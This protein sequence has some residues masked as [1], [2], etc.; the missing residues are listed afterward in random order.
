V[1][2]HTSALK[3]VT[4]AVHD[5]TIKTVEEQMQHLD[6]QLHGLDDVVVRI[7]EQNNIHHAA[8][9]ASLSHLAS[10][11]QMSYSSIGDHFTTSFS[12]VSELDEEI[13]TRTS[14]LQETLPLLSADGE[15]R[16]PLHTLREAIENQALEEYK[17]TGETPQRTNYNIS[18]ALPRTEAHETLLSKLRRR[19][20]STP[21]A[22]PAK[23]SL[24]SPSKG[25]I[26]ADDASADVVSLV[27]TSTRPG[28]S[29]SSGE[30]N[31]SLRELDVNAVHAMHADRGEKVE[32]D[33]LGPLS[34]PPLKRQNTTGNGGESRLP[35][36]KRGTRMTVAGAGSAVV[37][38]ANQENQPINLSASVGPG[39]VVGRRLR[40][41]G[42]S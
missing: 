28:T 41:N 14:S 26:F 29:S 40:S 39:S 4:T 11:V 25:L 7:K 37:V 5:S 15:V 24:R 33:G 30:G 32:K 16:R 13:S 3:S 2:E 38:A 8:H 17:A 27:P 1:N 23:S 34:M 21:P 22:S 9:V 6:T 10:N 36:K 20:A 35:L 12:R 42:S 18:V 31:L 19:S